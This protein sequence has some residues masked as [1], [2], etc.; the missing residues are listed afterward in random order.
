MSSPPPP[1]YGYPPPGHGY[2]RPAPSKISDPWTGWLLLAAAV[3]G[4]AGSLSPWAYVDDLH[5]TLWGGD[6]DGVISVVCAGIVGVMGLLIG[7]RQGRLWTPI[8]AVV[9][10][11]FTLLIGLID[12]VDVSTLYEGRGDVPQD[13]VTTAFGL[14]L[15]VAGGG[16]T[17]ALSIVALVRRRA[18][19]PTSQ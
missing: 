7:L 11:V 10:A 17:I 15:V 4:M 8:V 14:Y 19:A 16:L 12:L 5:L 3:V 9:F 13:F 18:A 2:P 6:R 1:G